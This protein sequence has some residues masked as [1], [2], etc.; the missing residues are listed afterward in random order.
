MPTKQPFIPISRVLH[1]HEHLEE[2]REH[3]S[4]NNTHTP[5]SLILSTIPMVAAAVVAWRELLH[6]VC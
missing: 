5:I 4:N 6:L 1:M 2:G 3:S